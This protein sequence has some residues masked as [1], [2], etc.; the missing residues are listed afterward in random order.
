MR[1]RRIYRVA[2]LAAATCLALAAPAS[3]QVIRLAGSVRDDAGRPI[4]G[5][6]I[7][8]ENPDQAPPRVSTTSNDKGQ[9]GLI[10]I[11]RGLWTITIDAPGFDAIQ[12]RRQVTATPRQDPLDVRLI[13]SAAPAALPLE[14]VKASDVQQRIDRA[15]ELAASGDLDGAIALWREI[16]VKVPALTAVN[17]RIGELYERKADPERA[18]AAYRQLLAVDPS[19]EKARAAVERLTRGGIIYSGTV[20]RDSQS[21]QSIGTVNRDSHR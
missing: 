11:R 4:R 20:N 1:A 10:G 5:A 12:F 9:F 13:K 18:L 3:A 19:N 16:L 6:V 21:G 14:G 15:E 2:L 8:A 7:V 17:L